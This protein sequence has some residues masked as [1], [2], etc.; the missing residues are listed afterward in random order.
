[1]I[2]CPPSVCVCV[3]VCVCACVWLLAAEAALTCNVVHVVSSVRVCVCV[4]GACVCVW[5]CGSSVGE[6]R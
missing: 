4:R 2:W 6:R 5:V 3:C 1:M